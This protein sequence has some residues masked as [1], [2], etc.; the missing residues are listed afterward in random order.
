MQLKLQQKNNNIGVFTAYIIKESFL[1]LVFW[2]IHETEKTSSSILKVLKNKICQS[3]INFVSFLILHMCDIFLFVTLY[4]WSMSQKRR[5][6]TN[7]Q[8]QI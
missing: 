3:C 5:N 6:L 7:T 1:T 4:L 8:L 2:M